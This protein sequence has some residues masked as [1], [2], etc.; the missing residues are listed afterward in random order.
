MQ[1][2]DLTK[3]ASTGLV[4]FLIGASI[5]AGASST[6]A[7]DLPPYVTNEEAILERPSVRQRII[8]E[9]HYGAAPIEYRSFERRV[10]EHR[11][12]QDY[13]G[14]ALVPPRYLPIV[15]VE[16]SEGYEGPALVPPQYVP[17][18]PVE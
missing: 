14:P 9:E 17:I 15:P 1:G 12:L 4:V 16:E 3:A 7:A 18:V 2:F 5:L 6:Q 11:H 10:V 13:E 8:V